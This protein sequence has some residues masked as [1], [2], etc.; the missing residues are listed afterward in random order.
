MNDSNL[1]GM[2]WLG[3]N[4][5]TVSRGKLQTGLHTKKNQDSIT[6]NFGVCGILFFDFNF[7]L[8]I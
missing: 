8:R 3:R 4:E 5:W 1:N 7:P 2:W 6:V